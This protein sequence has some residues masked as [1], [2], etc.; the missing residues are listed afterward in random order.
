M[1]GSWISAFLM[2]D[3]GLSLGKGFK[4]ST[5][6]PYLPR[7][8][9]VAATVLCLFPPAV[10]A[11]DGASMAVAALKPVIV[12]ASRQEQF[13]DD[14]PVSADVLDA[15]DLERGQI[16]DIRDAARDLPNVSVRHAPARFALTGPANSTGRDGNAGFTIRGLGGNRVLM[17]VD[18]VR[19]PRSYAFGGNAFGRDYLSLDLVK[20][21]EVVR[22][23]ASALY[24]SDGMGGLVNFMTWEP[25]DLL[26]GD[27][28]APRRAG[29]RVAAAWSGDDH[30]RGA[31]ATVAARASDTV[32]WL[33]SASWRGAHELD[34]R[35]DNDAA[36]PTR[37]RPNPQRDRDR[38]LLAKVVLRPGAGHKHVLT[39]EHVDRRADV[40]LLSS[41]AA[42]PLTGTPAQQAAA[43]LDERAWG[44]MERNRLTWNGRIR[45][46]SRLADSLDAVVGVQE[47][48]SRQ[49]G[50]SD[51]NA[52]PDRERDVR[53]DERTWHASAQAGKS[54]A[55]A[56][57]QSLQLTYGIEYLRSK[58]TNLYTGVNSLPPEVFP[59]K[60][61]PDTRESTAALYGQ[62]EWTAGPW[63]VVPG[64]RLDR[65]ELEVLT[66]AG[67]F[68]PAKTPARSLSGSA[69]SPKL[70]VMFR[71]D[72]TWS[73]FGSAA[74]GF[75]APNANQ[76]NGYYE[77]TA[78][79]VVVVPNPD[80]QPEKSRTLEVGLR[81]RSPGFSVD[82]ALFTGRFSNLI[83]DTVL[84]SGTGTAADP[85][86]FQTRNVE[87]ARIHGFEAKGRVE[88]G[89]LG[90]GRLGLPFAFGTARGVNR[91]TGR[92]LN[93]VDPWQLT[94]GV[95]Y[96][97]ASWD[98]RLDLRHQAAKKAQDIDSVALVK[99]PNTQITV[100]S[101]TT[102]DLS[103]Q[104]R[105]RKDLRLTASIV[106]L[107][108]RKY[109]L[110]SDV[111]GLAASTPAA[112]AY[113]QPGR[114][115]RVS[116]VAQF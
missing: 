100:P 84:V 77:N 98:L 44:T 95:D 11:D 66:Q 79:H 83:V 78:E 57:N 75:R 71:A 85:K 92:P 6:R 56:G 67:F 24:G 23:A 10:A 106:N 5:A 104:W 62:G 7:F 110:W 41:R 18:G 50:T 58:I 112:D 49:F 45:L 60:R 21:V 38:A 8:T 3:S 81:G 80:L 72:D 43:V 73:V 46:E 36:D 30:G 14:L 29:G 52:R 20:R 113:T 93:S 111:Q 51:L 96:R 105:L 94:A 25:A 91:T 88:A 102:L 47:A 109:W 108:D 16:Q 33:A 17:L 9:P 4:L 99:P 101:A 22:G 2:Q 19:V 82:L 42:L 116:L 40:D 89:R 76:V 90:A 86:L 59:L 27:G 64:L 70:G 97:T 107:T 69:A 103:G 15:T 1:N 28:G 53:Y 55:L 54:V 31:A 26:A 34:T 63:T 48:A 32:E 65:F 37:T 87:R 12:S 74:G 35:G 115:L 68:P 114:H 39:G 13:S 61:F